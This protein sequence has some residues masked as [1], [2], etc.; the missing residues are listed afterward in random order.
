MKY[1]RVTRPKYFCVISL[2]LQ[3]R[4]YAAVLCRVDIGVRVI[5][6]IRSWGNRLV[7]GIAVRPKGMG[8]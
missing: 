6:K 8:F 3:N 2:L 4:A 7:L 1:V 5:F